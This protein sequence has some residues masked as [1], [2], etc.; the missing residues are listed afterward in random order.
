MDKKA[1]NKALIEFIIA[2]AVFGTIGIFRR[3]IPL[4]S[5]LIAM[6][7][8]FI[9]ALYILASLRIKGRPFSFSHMSRRNA[10]II[11]INGAVM[12]F[13][14]I[15]LFE[16]YNYTSISTATLCYYMQ[17]IFLILIS[18]ILFKEKITMP[19]LLC[20]FVAVIGMVFVSGIIGTGVSTGDVKG[21]AFGLASALLYAI[22]VSTS[23]FVSEVDPYEKTALQLLGAAVA[24]IPYLILKGV[25][26]DPAALAA[27]FTPLTVIMLLLVCVVHTGITYTMYFGSLDKLKMQQVAI[28]GYADPVVAIILSQVIL[29]ESMGWNGVV[30]A[31]LILGAAF[32]SEIILK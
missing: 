30:G 4:D 21:I 2:M 10:I 20:V 18:P 9:G 25:F 11:I 23:K 3:F 12:G 8:G 27:S 7:R 14:W 6:T 28:F 16:A 22:V 26:A 32:V 17:P 29:G 15:T 31:I 19:K 1:N 13:N 24:V 5:G